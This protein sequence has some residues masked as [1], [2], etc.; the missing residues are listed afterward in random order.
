MLIC[1][2]RKGGKWCSVGGGLLKFG[3]ACGVCFIWLL[4]LESFWAVFRT[5]FS[6][7]GSRLDVGPQRITMGFV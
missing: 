7:M 3:G 4:G 5:E 2:S 6:H 1:T